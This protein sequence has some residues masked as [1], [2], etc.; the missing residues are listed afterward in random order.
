MRPKIDL[1][2][3]L[4]AVASLEMT[5]LSFLQAKIRFFFN[6]MYSKVLLY[7]NSAKQMF[8]YFTT[9][10]LPAQNMHNFYIIKIDQ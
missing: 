7:V 9:A 10:F 6:S 1:P 2:L 4:F 3:F 5:Q 8:Q